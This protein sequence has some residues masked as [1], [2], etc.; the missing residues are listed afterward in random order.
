MP[1]NNYLLGGQ[2]LN[3]LK[4]I[5]NNMNSIKCQ[6]S[7]EQDHW[8]DMAIEIFWGLV[9]KNVQSLI[10]SLTVTTDMQWEYS[11]LENIYYTNVI[12]ED[13]ESQKNKNNSLTKNERMLF[14]WEEQWRE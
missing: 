2:G 4:W 12:N 10:T 8:S 14:I 3:K 1:S 7:K 11:V 9:F 5:N 13:I 6:S